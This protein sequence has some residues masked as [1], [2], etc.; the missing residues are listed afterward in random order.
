VRHF[1]EETPD[2]LPMVAM[3]NPIYLSR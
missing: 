3:T 2:D 1:A